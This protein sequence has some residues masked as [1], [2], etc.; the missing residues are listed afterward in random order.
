MKVTPFKHKKNCRSKCKDI[1]YNS[2]YV[3]YCCGHCGASA[4]QNTAEA[5]FETMKRRKI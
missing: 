3:T 2:S 5:L 1:V 4:V